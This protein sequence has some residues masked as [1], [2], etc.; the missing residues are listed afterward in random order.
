MQAF[1]P[2]AAFLVGGAAGVV[3]AGLLWVRRAS[4]LPA[5]VLQ[6]SAHR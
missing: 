4:L 5:Q 2:H 3:V 6:L 1:G